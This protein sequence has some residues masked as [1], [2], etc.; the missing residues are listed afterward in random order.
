MLLV[1]SPL[2]VLWVQTADMGLPTTLMLHLLLNF[3]HS[4]AFA[5][6]HRLHLVDYLRPKLV[7]VLEIILVFAVHLP[8]VLS[9][10]ICCYSRFRYLHHGLEG[11]L[12]VVI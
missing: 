4:A 6:E 7:E 10:F 2:V 11:L 12:D 3:L 5:F 1:D 9:R 8:L